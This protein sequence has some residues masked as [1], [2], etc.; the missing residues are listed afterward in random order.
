VRV[1]DAS[2]KFDDVGPTIVKVLLAGS[3][4]PWWGAREFRF[5]PRTE[6]ERTKKR[7]LPSV[8]NRQMSHVS[9]HETVQNGGPQSL[10]VST[11]QH[12]IIVRTTK[13]S[14]EGNQR[15]ILILILISTL[16]MATLIMVRTFLC[17]FLAATCTSCGDC[18]ERRA[19]EECSS[20]RSLQK[21][22]DDM[23]GRLRR[24]FLPRLS[25]STSQL[26]LVESVESSSAWDL[27]KLV[28]DPSSDD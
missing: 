15:N 28:H 14:Q 6:N 19:S 10:L 25:V 12:H 16:I 7:I 8:P 5:E 18:G 17:Q 22:V 27:V 11:T 23:F 3:S 2:A 21:T 13:A 4:R 24:Y 9:K 20:A 26:L 1:L